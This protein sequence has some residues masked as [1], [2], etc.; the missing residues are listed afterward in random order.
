MSTVAQHIAQP[1]RTFIEPQIEQLHI[2]MQAHR[3]GILGVLPPEI[4]AG[5]LWAL[6]IDNDCLITA[7]HIELSSKTIL[8]E[9]PTE[10]GCICCVSQ[11]TVESSQ[12]LL[13]VALPAHFENIATFSHEG[14]S[15]ATP[16]EAHAPYDSISICYT[17]SFIHK[18]RR[19]YPKQCSNL[20]E[21]L[22][23]P[24]SEQLSSQLLAVMRGINPRKALLRGSELFFHAKALEAISLVTQSAGASAS[25]PLENAPSIT[26]EAKNYIKANLAHRFTLDD[27][28]K[29]VFTSRSKLC[30]QFQHD[31]GMGIAAYTRKQRIGQAQSLLVSTRLSIAEVGTLVGYPRPS[32]FTEAFV[33]EAHSTPSEW[34]MLHT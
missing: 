2:T 19:R 6:S 18:L 7:H 3:C 30:A 21:Q 29:H 5:F 17:S 13:H 4:G 10:Y 11:P 8:D 14:G 31:T 12:E 34:R 32:S 16:L 27:V 1:L 26:Q 20:E 24:V 28:S 9:Y 15:L 22:N 23:T 33:R 25:Q